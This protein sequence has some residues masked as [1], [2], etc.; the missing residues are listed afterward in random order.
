VPRI[1][2]LNRERM[3]FSTHAQWSPRVGK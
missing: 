1:A 3:E 2:S